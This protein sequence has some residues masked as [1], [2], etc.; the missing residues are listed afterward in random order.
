MEYLIIGIVLGVLLLG[1]LVYML[2]Y[3][4]PI[5]KHVYF[6]RL[7]RETPEKWGRDICSAPENE[8]QQAMWD[9]G[10]AWAE[11]H[12]DCMREVQIEND[13]LHLYGEYYDFGKERC[14]IVLP[15]RCESLVYSYFFAPPYEK[16]GFNVLVIDTR[17][18]GKSDGTYNT[19]GVQESGDVIAWSNFAHQE[20]GNKEVYYHGICVGTSAAIFA[21]ER[22]DCPDCVKGLVTEGCFVSFRETFKQHMI[23]DKRP[24]FPVLDLVMLNIRRYT[25]TNVYRQKP[26]SAIK[27]IKKDARVLFL[28]GKQD[29]FSLPP[30][31]QKLFEACAAQD[32]KLVW[33]E[34]GAHSHLRISNPD[35]YD[36][37]I[38][39]FFK[40]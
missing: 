35:T 23:V 3:T 10:I 16:A 22:K 1:G 6:T 21:L 26:I 31:S 38:V 25:G 5:A 34:K 8:E 14:V 28:F 19:I 32:K 29:L 2:I 12:K 27:R 36:Q 11:S 30:K 37:H 9:Q 17:C 39:D 33:F 13:G 20:L 40:D 4:Y 24:L 7:V 15:G 18:H